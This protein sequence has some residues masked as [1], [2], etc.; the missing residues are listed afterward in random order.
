MVSYSFQV[1]GIVE[2]DASPIFFL[3]ETRA[4]SIVFAI[5]MRKQRISLSNTQKSG[6]INTTPTCMHKFTNSGYF[7]G[8]TGKLVK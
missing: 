5:Q 1:H 4:E 7:D 6:L 2:V 8:L 3:S